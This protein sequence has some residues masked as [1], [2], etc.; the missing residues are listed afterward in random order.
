MYYSQPKMASIHEVVE[1]VSSSLAVIPFVTMSETVEQSQ[2]TINNE[3]MTILQ[4]I[5]YGCKCVFILY[6]NK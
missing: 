1:I 6:L 4:S 3:I 5:L 2:L